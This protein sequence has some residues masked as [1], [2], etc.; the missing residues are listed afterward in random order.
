MRFEDSLLRS[1]DVL[2]PRGGC[3]HPTDDLDSAQTMQRSVLPAATDRRVIK[4]G[5]KWE[6]P[7]EPLPAECAGRWDSS[8]AWMGEGR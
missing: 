7:T 6:T 4:E 8:F 2:L 5:L 1:S 3:A